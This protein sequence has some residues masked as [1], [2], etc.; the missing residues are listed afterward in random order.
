M[1]TVHGTFGRQ[2]G[3]HEHSD[4][5]CEYLL[6]P[7]TGHEDRLCLCFFSDEPLSRQ[8]RPILRLCK[9]PPT[10]HSK[11]CMTTWPRPE[12]LS[13]QARARL[14]RHFTS[15][16]RDDIPL[17]VSMRASSSALPCASRPGYACVALL[18]YVSAKSGGCSGKS[19]G[20]DGRSVKSTYSTDVRG[21]NPAK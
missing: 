13:G 4:H 17:G 20:F 19:N 8:H 21:D 14:T 15:W 12:T 16:V 18:A 1:C 9:C 10:P 3:G 11:S 7:P 6:C 2:N 5:I